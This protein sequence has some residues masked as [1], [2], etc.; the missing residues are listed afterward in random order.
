MA[1]FRVEKS[2]GYTVMSNHHLFDSGISLKAKGLLSIMLSMPDGWD[3][4]LAGLAENNRDGIEA[5]RAAFNEL[6]NAG[7]LVRQQVKREDGKFTGNK[8]I[9]QEKPMFGEGDVL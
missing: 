6:V 2:S 9:I 8:Y 7:Y 1:E 5:I 3:Y 4:T